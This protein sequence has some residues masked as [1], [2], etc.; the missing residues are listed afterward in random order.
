MPSVDHVH[1]TPLI[2]LYLLWTCVAKTLTM[3]T[4]GRAQVLHWDKTISWHQFLSVWI[5]WLSLYFTQQLKK[6]VDKEK[7][8]FKKRTLWAWQ[9]FISDWSHSF[10]LNSRTQQRK[11]RGTALLL[12][13]EVFPVPF[14]T[15]RTL[16]ECTR[17]ANICN[18]KWLAG[19]TFLLQQVALRWFWSSPPHEE[20]T[21]WGDVTEPRAQPKPTK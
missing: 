9:L 15:V 11:R 14:W 19:V 21:R 16:Q 1:N 4:P 12:R 2:S 20:G 5:E 18:Y 7:N 10:S 6:F 17:R 8:A 3:I 13:A